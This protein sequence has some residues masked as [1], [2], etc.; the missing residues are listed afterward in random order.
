MTLNN[1][2]RINL[3]REYRYQMSGLGKGIN[4]TKITVVAVTAVVLGVL[5][6]LSVT[7]W[8]E[9]GRLTAE[10]QGLELYVKS[11]EVAA[12][13]AE[14][15][16]LEA[17]LASL[18]DKLFT[19]ENLRWAYDGLNVPDGKLFAALL[20][21]KPADVWISYYAFAEGK[22]ELECLCESDA[23]PSAYAAALMND[24]VCKALFSEVFYDGYS[25]EENGSVRFSLTLTMTP[26]HNVPGEAEG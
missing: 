23:S 19:L 9:S 16:A 5:L 26:K 3:F 10:K 12:R 24:D 21:V 25:A 2:K 18:G 6:L 20:A 22:A 11:P 17:E 1:T 15:D 14:V 4:Y 8:A 13:L 7:A